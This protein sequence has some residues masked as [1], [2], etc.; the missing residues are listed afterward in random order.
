MGIV[1]LRS[2]T[3]TKPN[4]EMRE[5]MA[6]ANVGDD[7]YGEDPT[8]N[9]LEELAAWHTGKEEAVFTPSGT[10][11]NLIAILSWTRPGDE[12]MVGSE[13]HIFWNEVGGA[14]AL[15]GVL[16]RTIPNEHSGRLNTD[17]ISLAIRGSN[18]HQPPTRLLC[19]EN[20]HN[21]CSGAVLTPLDTQRTADLM[22]SKDIP[23]HLDGARIF[24][25]AVALKLPTQ[26]LT[27]RVDSVSFCLSKGLGAPVGSLLCGT[28]DFIRRA[29][30][31]RK[32]L[33]GGMRQAGVLA[34]A[35]VVAL[36]TMIERLADDHVN[37]HALANG[38]AK[39]PGIDVDPST[40]CTNIVIFK[41]TAGE[42]SIFLE[43]LASHGIMAASPGGQFVR[44]VTHAD[45][46]MD[47]VEA[48]I[49]ATTSVATTLT[50]KP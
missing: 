36:N 1:E 8:V 40:I 37:A 28:S 11:S 6:R 50:S 29:R 38:L 30:K 21:R 26:S 18:I 13:S 34:A 41:W 35:G 19:L 10:M 7:V 25:A 39:V 12:I 23:I 9:H 22:G 2:D 44:M 4:A 47:D 33:G 31:W 15:G 45:V 17:D 49:S 24:N 3:F 43:K 16:M 32:M 42:V 48:T 20:T 5:A 46:G 27:E 14:S